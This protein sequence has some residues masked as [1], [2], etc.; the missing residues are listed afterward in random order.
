M[1]NEK[2]LR[3]R[4]WRETSG[5]CIYCGHPVSLEEMEMDHIEPKSFGGGNNSANLVC[6]CH[7]CNAEKG[8][9]PL[10]VHLLD[11]SEGKLRR[12]V[13]RVETLLDQGKI[14]LDK[15]DALLPLEKLAS[16]EEDFQD[17][18]FQEEY[19]TDIMSELEDVAGILIELLPKIYRICQR[20]RRKIMMN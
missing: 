3:E 8:G 15:A 19:D 18:E 4:I 17:E 12:Y 2:N 7:H 13:N 11:W 10:E 5:H 6:S 16:D 14:S 9:E 1:K 20:K